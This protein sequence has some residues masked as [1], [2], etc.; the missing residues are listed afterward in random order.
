MTQIG[1]PRNIWP[2]SLENFFSS[3]IRSRAVE[4]GALQLTNYPHAEIISPQHFPSIQPYLVP[5][6]DL[7][8][9][10][11]LT[12]HEDSKVTFADWIVGIAEEEPEIFE[13]LRT[14]FEG[15]ARLL[16]GD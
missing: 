7:K 4:A 3:T 12:T 2:G 5:R 15:V 1:L 10:N 11:I 6:E 14:V 16:E 8:H 13:P 9:F